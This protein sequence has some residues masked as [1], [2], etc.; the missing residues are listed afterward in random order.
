[1]FKFPLP[2][3]RL[4]EFFGVELTQIAIDVGRD[5]DLIRLGKEAAPRPVHI[6]MCIPPVK[7]SLVC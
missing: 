7:R 6:G 5:T 2:L 3:L 1:M 4:R